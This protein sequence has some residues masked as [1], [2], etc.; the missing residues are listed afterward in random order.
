VDHAGLDDANLARAAEL[1]PDGLSVRDVAEVLK[2]SKSATHRLRIKAR[3]K[4]L[5][6]E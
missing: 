6:G 4:R 3:E 5:L 2:V 1:F